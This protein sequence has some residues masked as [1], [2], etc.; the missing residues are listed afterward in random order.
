MADAEEEAVTGRVLTVTVEW[1]PPV[2]LNPNARTSDSTRRRLLKEGRVATALAIRSELRGEPFAPLSGPC[3]ITYTVHWPRGRKERDSDNA[4]AA[5]KGC[6]DAFEDEKIVGN[7][8]Q[9]VDDA[10][11]QVFDGAGVTVVTVEETA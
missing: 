8:R 1:V 10:V 11:T 4:K 6:R 3:R 5:F 9:F 7:D 2:K